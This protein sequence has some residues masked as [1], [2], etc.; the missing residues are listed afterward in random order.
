MVQHNIKVYEKSSDMSEI[1]TEANRFGHIWT[2]GNFWQRSYEYIGMRT[3]RNHTQSI[4]EVVGCHVLLACGCNLRNTL[5][6]T[7]P[8]KTK[9]PQLE[10]FRIIENES[11]H[12]QTQYITNVRKRL[13]KC[14]Q[15]NIH[16]WWKP[17]IITGKHNTTKIL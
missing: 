13:N 1:K 9:W 14:A 15:Q 8:T 7:H 5:A 3:V 11:E 2:D 10:I 12:L 4:G 16:P 6:K 17:A